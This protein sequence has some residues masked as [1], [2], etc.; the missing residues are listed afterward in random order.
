MFLFVDLFLLSIL[1]VLIISFSPVG[2]VLAEY[3]LGISSSKDN[4]ELTK[5]YSELEAKIK[6]QEEEIKNLREG[7]LM[8]DEKF[9]KLD[10]IKKND[11]NKNKNINT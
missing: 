4:V 7:Y 9:Q 3:F 5:K 8:Q 6:E 1:I 10:I 2:K 11:L